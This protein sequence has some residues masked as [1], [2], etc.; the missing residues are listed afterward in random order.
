M[1]IRLHQLA[2]RCIYGPVAGQH[3]CS[4]K[5]SRHDHDPEMATSIAGSRVTDVQVAFIFDF[6]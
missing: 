6:K 3:G 4:V 2:E 5:D 1:N